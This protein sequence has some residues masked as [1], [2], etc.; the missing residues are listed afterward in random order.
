MLT[1]GACTYADDNSNR[2]SA[3]A[4]E[5]TIFESELVSINSTKGA[6]LALLIENS[7][8][9]NLASY[10]NITVSDKLIEEWLQKDSPHLLTN[11]I[12]G[13]N[14]QNSEDIYKALLAVST[15]QLTKQLAYKKHLEPFMDVETWKHVMLQFSDKNALEAYKVELDKSDQQLR[16]QTINTF[17]FEYVLSEVEK[18][19]CASD[20]VKNKIDSAIAK[21]LIQ[22]SNVQAG[23]PYIKDMLEQKRKS[24]CRVFALEELVKLQREQVSIINTKFSNVFSL[25]ATYHKWEFFKKGLP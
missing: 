12:L 23:A 17:R 15:K 10:Y 14:R 6:M 13:R 20:A 21:K 9:N 5:K 18:K 3:I 19:T 25:T 2:P 4:F 16:E 24:Y 22:Y 8:R 11:N 7:M 1:I